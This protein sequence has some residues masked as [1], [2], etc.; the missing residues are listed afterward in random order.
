MKAMI[1]NR[2][3]DFDLVLGILILFVELKIGFLFSTRSCSLFDIWSLVL[4]LLKSPAIM[5]CCRCVIIA[6]N[7]YIYVSMIKDITTISPIIGY[8]F[9]IVIIVL[10]FD[11]STV[12][13]LA[14]CDDSGGLTNEQKYKILISKYYDICNHNGKPV[15]TVGVLSHKMLPPSIWP[16]PVFSTRTSM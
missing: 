3:G 1:L 14:Y 16:T 8:C 11:H 7:F 2:I 10:L 13:S 6:V 15:A 9:I 5:F 4:N 12:Y